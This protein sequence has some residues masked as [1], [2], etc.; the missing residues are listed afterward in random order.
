MT[1][2][3]ATVRA[4]SARRGGGTRRRQDRRHGSQRALRGRKGRGHAR[5]AAAL[6][7]AR[8]GLVRSAAGP[9]PPAVPPPRPRPAASRLGSPPG[10]GQELQLWLDRRGAETRRC[11]PRATRARRC[12]R[13]GEGGTLVSGPRED[14]R[15]CRAERQPESGRREAPSWDRLPSLGPSGQP[16]RAGALEVTEAGGQALRPPPPAAT[17]GQDG[18]ES[19]FYQRACRGGAGTRRAPLPGPRAQGEPEEAGTDLTGGT[20]AR[21]VSCG[22]QGVFGLAQVC[23]QTEWRFMGG[24]WVMFAPVHCL[25][26]ASAGPRGTELSVPGSVFRPQVLQRGHP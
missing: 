12:F 2:P 5:Q 17:P 15:R 6:P 24:R 20:G 16:P 14:A 21:P 22:V 19:V 26:T 9:P 25:R 18:Q 13:V 1:G 3:R 10:L 8:A 4:G 7:A 11:P 23:L